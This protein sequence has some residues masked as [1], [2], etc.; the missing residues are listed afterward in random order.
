M[1][2]FCFWERLHPDAFSRAKNK[3]LPDIPDAATMEKKGI[4]LGEMTKNLTQK[5]EELTLYIIELDRK[6]AELTKQVE[7][8]KKNQ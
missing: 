7:L 6:N 5:I 3:H 2:G 4:N 8:M 1:A